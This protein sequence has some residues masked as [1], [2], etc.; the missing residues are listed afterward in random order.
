MPLDELV[1]NYAPDIFMQIP[2]EAWDLTRINGLIYAVPHLTAWS[3]AQ[4]VMADKTLLEKYQIKFNQ[5]GT[6][7]ALD[8][9]LQKVF[10]GEPQLAGKLLGEVTG[11][12]DPRSWGYEPAQLPGVLRTNATART[13]MNWYATPEYRQAVETLNRWRQAGYLPNQPLKPDNLL[14]ARKIGEYPFHLTVFRKD[15]Q[16]QAD[17]QE[18]HPHDGMTFQPVLLSGV[19]NNLTGVC[20]NSQNPN[21]AL[22]FLNLVYT[23][24]GVYNLLAKGIEGV[25]W[26]W[27]DAGQRLITRPDILEVKKYNLHRDWMFGNQFL[28]YAENP[29]EVGTWQ[30]IAQQNNS[31]SVPLD[32]AFVFDPALVQAEMTAVEAVIARF[33]PGLRWGVVNPNDSNLG[34]EAFNRELQAAGLEKVLQ[35]MQRQLDAYLAMNF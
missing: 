2:R 5:A 34:I 16:A 9:A 4:G 7:P 31:A 32:G 6:I 28:A 33:D 3:E 11:V 12:G 25:H 8:E 29:Q 19:T 26:G 21:L 27:V 30:Q 15:L 10:Q 23:D 18:G 35:E 24:E 22:A 17:L 1:N 14:E 20:A 13:V